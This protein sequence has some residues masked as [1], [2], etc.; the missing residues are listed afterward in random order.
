MLLGEILNMTDIEKILGD[1]HQ[2]FVAVMPDALA[3]LQRVELAVHTGVDFDADTRIVTFIRER[4]EWGNS[5]GIARFSRVCIWHD[6]K[7]Q[8]RE[9]QYRDRWSAAHDNYGNYFRFAEIGDVSTVGDDLVINVT[10]RP[11]NEV[12][13]P[14][15]IQFTYKKE[16]QIPEIRVLSVEEQKE[17]EDFFESEMQR[18]LALKEQLWHSSPKKAMIS[19]VPVFRIEDTYIDYKH[20]SI[21]SHVL[22]KR[23]GIG[24]FITAVQIDHFATDR[25]LQYEVYLARHGMPKSRIIFEDHA[26]L[27]REGD[28]AIIGLEVDG[29]KVVFNTRRSG[30]REIETMERRS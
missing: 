12:Y 30:R 24:A 9:Y 2:E 18:V 1:R 25:Q 23:I 21:W 27:I 20:P 7:V 19:P 5:G 11:F 14:R 17:F 13:S 29:T 3:F 8:K 26:Y 6:G 22:D 4:S 16:P 10:A 15:S 28:P